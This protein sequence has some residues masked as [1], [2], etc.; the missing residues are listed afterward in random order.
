MNCGTPSTTPSTA[1]RQSPDVGLCHAVALQ[2][3]R[4]ITMEGLRESVTFTATVTASSPGGT[5]TG[6]VTFYDGATSLGTGTH[7]FYLDRQH[8][9]IGQPRRH[10]EALPMRNLFILLVLF[11]PLHASAG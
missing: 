7:V 4:L 9:H 3:G 11:V 1:S 6:T 10:S 8:C 5:P 2:S